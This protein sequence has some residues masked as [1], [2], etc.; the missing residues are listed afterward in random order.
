MEKKVSVLYPLK[1]ISKG[2]G[3]NKGKTR[4]AAYVRVSSKNME[5]LSSYNAQVKYFRKHIS[6]REDYEL[7]KIYADEGISGT[8][9]TKRMAFKEMIRDA[10]KGKIDLIITKSFSRFGRNT[11]D[12]LVTIRELKEKGV[13]VFFERENIHMMSSAGEMLLALLFATAQNE[14][15][16]ISENVK[17][18]IHK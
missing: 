6:E 1:N 13:D 18:G 11:V 4:V 10:K 14:S 5:Q 12:C 7:V 3:V 17:W 9:I 16:S 8:D 2:S 15:A